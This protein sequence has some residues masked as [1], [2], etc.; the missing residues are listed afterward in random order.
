[1]IPGKQLTPPRRVKGPAKGFGAT[2]MSVD[3]GP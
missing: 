2:E 1:M 3:F